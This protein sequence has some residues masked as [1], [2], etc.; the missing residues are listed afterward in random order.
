MEGVQR[1]SRLLR[2]R[3]L[4]TLFFALILA[5][6]I[7]SLRQTLGSFW[8]QNL[9]YVHLTR[10]FLAPEFNADE[11]AGARTS[12]AQAVS[13]QESNSRARWGL[14]QV[15]LQ[16]GDDAA[17]VEEWQ[18]TEGALPRLLT[19]SDAAFNA[20]DYAQ[21]LD[22]AVLALAHDPNSSSAHY[23]L[24]E[25]Y[26]ALGEP[27]RAL[28]EYQRAKE[29]NSFLPGDTADLASCYFGEARVYDAQEKWKTAVWHYEVGLELRPDAAAYA[30]LGDIYHYQL[31]DL[32]TAESYVQKA[33]ALEPT[34]ACWHVALG[35]VYIS[36]EKYGEALAELETAADLRDWDSEG[37]EAY[38]ALGQSYY[39]LGQY[40]KAIQA[41]QEA[42][43]LDPDSSSAT[44]GLEAVLERVQGEREDT[45]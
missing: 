36:Q 25:A 20:N 29:L 24:G 2:S 7:L 17:A 10:A 13:W 19:A 22:Q 27:D 41:F 16:L 12:F 30:S 18:R 15:Y 26:R 11:L 43:I 4:G 39:G 45:I 32:P 8:Y 38:V 28:S 44:Q 34:Q 37:A 21:A 31:R 40:E 33:I 3:K 23:R 6:A 42:L 14:G 1:R 5:I 35:E 9:G